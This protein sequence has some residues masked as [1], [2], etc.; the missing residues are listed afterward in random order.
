LAGEN[1]S[2]DVINSQTGP[3]SNQTKHKKLAK[4]TKEMKIRAWRLALGGRKRLSGCNKQPNWPGF[5]S[6]QTKKKSSKIAK[7]KKKT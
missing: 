3:G 6:D 7:L 1:V 2:Q 4:K 5:K